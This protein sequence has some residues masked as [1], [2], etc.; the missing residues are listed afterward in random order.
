MAPGNRLI[1]AMADQSKLMVDLPGNLPNCPSCT[2]E[3][4][5]LSGTSM[6]APMVAGTAA[7][8][9]TQDPSLSRTT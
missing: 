2:D 4:L 9:L 3:Y 8:M 1:A 6:A 7:L 5:E